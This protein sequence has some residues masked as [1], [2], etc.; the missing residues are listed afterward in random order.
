MAG[1]TRGTVVLD[2]GLQVDLRILP[3]E[4]YGAALQY[5]TGSKPHNVRLR[6]RAVAMG[7]SIS[8]YG[9]FTADGKDGNDGKD[10]KPA[11]VGRRVAGDT[12]ESVYAAVGLPW[13]PPELREDRGEIEAAEEGTLPALLTLADIR[14]D[15]QMHSTWSDGKDTIAAMVDACIARGYA[16]CAL[17]DHSKTLAMTGGLDAERLRRQWKELDAVLADRPGIRV[18]RSLEVDI[19]RDGSLDLEDEMLERLDFVLVAIHTLLDLP[20]AEQ[21]RRIVRALEHPRVHALAHPTARLINRRDPMTF[22]L[23]EVLLCARERGVAVELNAHPSRLDLRDTHLLR[24][25]EL[26]VPVVIGTDAHHAR[27]LDYMRYGVEQARRAWLEP[28]HVLNT[29]PLDAFLAALRG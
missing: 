17:T 26:G 24:A 28:R 29:R 9:V 11:P 20:A 1:D 6:K 16:Y 23:E 13:I 27:D 15:L 12:E 22:D 18:L 25:R 7:L 3:A 2:S 19:L 14:A 8:E 5:F 21:T 4:S 10:G